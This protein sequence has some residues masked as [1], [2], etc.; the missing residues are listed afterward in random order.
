M[1]VLVQ[2]VGSSAMACRTTGRALADGKGH[3]KTDMVLGAWYAVCLWM[4]VRRLRVTGGVVGT[5]RLQKLAVCEPGRPEHVNRMAP[6]LP[7]HDQFSDHAPNDRRQLEPMPAESNRPVET[8][9]GTGAVEDG[10]AVGRHIVESAVAAPAD[11]GGEVR[12]PLPRAVPKAR[13]SAVVGAESVG[14]R[15]NDLGQVLW[16]LASHQRPMVRVRPEVRAR[17][18]VDNGCRHRFKRGRTPEADHLDADGRYGQ[19]LSHGSRQPVAPGAGR[20][21][22]RWRFDQTPVGLDSGDSPAG[23]GQSDYWRLSEY[24]G[25]VVALTAI[26][27][28]LLIVCEQ[29]RSKAANP[30]TT[31]SAPSAG[32]RS[33]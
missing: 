33:P 3:M 17:R 5:L 32:S 1:T 23:C 2:Q 20:D 4:P 31:A 13:N 22:D 24:L 6:R 9:H 30:Y 16:R 7:I 19:R 8:F 12:E 29:N 18:V 26:L 15:V 11:G 25:A 21:D 10:V 27:M 14:V 28:F